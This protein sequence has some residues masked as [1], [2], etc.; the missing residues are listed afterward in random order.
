MIRLEKNESTK[1]D[2][3]KKEAQG[4]VRINLNWSQGT[5][6]KGL[7]G[8]FGGK[9]SAVDL[10]LGALY[11]LQN[12]QKGAVQAL[13]NAFGSLSTVPFVQ[14]AGDDRSGENKDGEWMTVSGA[15]WGDI[16][17]LLVYAFIYKGAPSWDSTNSVLTVYPPKGDPIHIQLAG[18]GSQS[19]FCIGALIE[20]DNGQMKVT[21]VDRYVDGHRSAD[22]AFGW[23]L[24]WQAG[25]KE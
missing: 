15:H 9:S 8:M 2:L 21:R 12:G 19:G 4:D 20:N 24:N 17:R 7:M 6:K 13:G 22:Q 3:S 11:E 1:I 10:D 16:R 14:L 18:D 5:A 23:G 25:S